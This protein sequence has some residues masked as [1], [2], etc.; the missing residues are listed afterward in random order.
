MRPQEVKT[1]LKFYRAGYD[2]ASMTFGIAGMLAVVALA[3]LM[4][5]DPLGLYGFGTYTGS[6]GKFLFD[7]SFYQPNSEIEY[8]DYSAYGCVQEW[9][10]TSTK[11]FGIP[12]LFMG[13]VYGVMI[14]ATLTVLAIVLSPR[15]ATRALAANLAIEKTLGLLDEEEE[16]K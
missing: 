3:A 9:V 7:C 6:D 16:E 1:A 2:K 11:M 4:V 13:F 8:G 5:T 15:R 14:V 12:V 10:V